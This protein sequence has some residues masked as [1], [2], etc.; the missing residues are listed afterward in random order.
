M[1]I[2]LFLILN[3]EVI[4]VYATPQLSGDSSLQEVGREYKKVYEDAFQFKDWGNYYQGYLKNF[5]SLPD[6]EEF[7]SFPKTTQDLINK[8]ITYLVHDGELP[9]FLD[10]DNQNQNF[11]TWNVDALYGWYRRNQDHYCSFREAHKEF[12]RKPKP[13][14]R[15]L[16]K[17][18][19]KLSGAR[20]YVV[21]NKNNPKYIW[22]TS[23]NS[24][25]TRGSQFIVK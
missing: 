1:E 20:L 2:L 14:C 19:Y 16:L 22:V 21:W 7:A 25:S 3:S 24:I 12:G 23:D 9:K 4:A 18:K 8:R 11:F 17:K 13:W 15:K 6:S 10:E 5:N